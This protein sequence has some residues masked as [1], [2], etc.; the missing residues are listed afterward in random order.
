MTDEQ[1][2][3]LIAADTLGLLKV[4]PKRTPQSS[5]EERVQEKFLA[6]VRFVEETGGPPSKFGVTLIER[7]L[8]ESLDAIRRNPQWCVQ[9][10]ALDDYGVLQTVEERSESLTHSEAATAP[11]PKAVA[12][13]DPPPP[14]TM[15]ELLNDDFFRLPEQ[16]T[17]DMFTLKHVTVKAEPAVP[18]YIAQRRPC[19]D[20]AQ[21]QPQLEA[22][23]ADLKH[24]RRR[25]IGFAK[26]QRIEIGKFFTLRGVLLQ[27]VAISTRAAAGE[28]RPCAGPRCR[29]SFTR[30]V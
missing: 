30:N 3:Q 10:K 6:I 1:L 4:P 2:A 28:H 7:G 13:A 25:L 23:Q 24:G 27:V 11:G 29:G 18:D 20:F 9:L 26:E 22:C 5:A 19:K 17:H 16:K 21:F 14:A 15:D 8:Y 12:P